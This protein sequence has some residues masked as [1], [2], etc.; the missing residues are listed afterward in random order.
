[1]NQKKPSI[2]NLIDETV[3]LFHRLRVVA[4]ELHGGGE[5]AAGKRGVLKGLY[6]IGPQTVPQMARARPVSRQHIQSLVNPLV[7][8]GYVEFI[9]NPHH[10]R[11]KLV[12]LTG[13]G[14]VFV[15]KMQL[16]E[17][18]VFQTLSAKFSES[19]LT[20][21]TRTLRSVRECFEKE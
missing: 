11:S 7:E 15:E 16:R 9:D 17:A 19:R 10:R 13:T 4:D 3:L 5:L 1:M 2:E 8:E 20:Q 21:A 6:E 14:R 18:E 12:Q